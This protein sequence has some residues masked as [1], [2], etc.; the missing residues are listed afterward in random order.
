MSELVVRPT[1]PADLDALAPLFDGYRRFYEQP[2]DLALARN[3]IGERL[4]RM[5]TVIFL[6]EVD[7]KPAGFTHLFPI[8]SSTRCRRLWLL[9]DLFVDPT[10]R[11]KGVGKALLLAARAY[12]QS[13]D[14]CGLEL[15]TAHTNKPAQR[16]YESM[17]WQLDQTFRHYEIAVEPR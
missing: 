3:F 9:N 4:A 2:S 17:G 13:T 8:F 7:G 10:T 11:T 1:G 6:A 5:D 16:L 15:A 14:A 12:A